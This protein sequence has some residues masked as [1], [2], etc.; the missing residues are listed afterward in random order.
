VVNLWV[1]APQ[2]ISATPQSA[3]IP[4]QELLRFEKHNMEDK[5]CGSVAQKKLKIT[6]IALA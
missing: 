4:M 5:K 2:N 6:S 3:G 1:N